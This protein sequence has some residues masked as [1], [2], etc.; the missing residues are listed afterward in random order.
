MLARVLL[1]HN[2]DGTDNGNVFLSAVWLYVC[3]YIFKCTYL[4]IQ[5][6]PLKIRTHIHTC[7]YICCINTSTNAC[8][9]AWKGVAFSETANYY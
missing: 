8:T 9:Q 3:N 2:I 5:K 7:K 4:L 1:L 6:S